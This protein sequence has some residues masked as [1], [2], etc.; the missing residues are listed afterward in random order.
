MYTIVLFKCHRNQFSG[1]L[2]SFSTCI[3]LSTFF[4]QQNLFSGGLPSF[5]ACIKLTLV[6][7]W[8]NFFSG[9]LPSFNNLTNLVSFDCQNNQFS[10]NIPSFSGCTSLQTLECASN[11]FSGILPIAPT[12]IVTY[13]FGQNRT[14]ALEVPI[15]VVYGCTNL[16]TFSTYKSLIGGARTVPDI[17]TNTKLENLYFN[18]RAVAGLIF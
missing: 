2:P 17:S 11:E 6:P 7:C 9:A 10:G 15:N 5:N 4:A 18:D 8:T 12:S 13:S 16:V 3:N 1:I 14:Y